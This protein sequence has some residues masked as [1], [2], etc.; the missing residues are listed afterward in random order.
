MEQNGTQSAY[1]GAKGPEGVPEIVH[2]PFRSQQERFFAPQRPLTVMLP[3]LDN[4][5]KTAR[6]HLPS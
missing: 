3:N 2:G 1:I 4:R 5:G 6:Y